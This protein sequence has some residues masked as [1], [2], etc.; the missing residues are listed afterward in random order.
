MFFQCFKIPFPK[1]LFT[2]KIKFE[3]FYDN[4]APQ[5]HSAKPFLIISL[6]SESFFDANFLKYCFLGRI[7]KVTIMFCG[8]PLMND[9]QSL[10][11]VEY[12]P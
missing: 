9:P 4:I 1:M 2:E 8:T 10:L 5:V 7:R 12:C 6:M 3:G 11:S